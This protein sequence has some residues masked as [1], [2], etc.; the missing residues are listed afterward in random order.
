MS[1]RSREF[2]VPRTGYVVDLRAAD[3]QHPRSGDLRLELTVNRPAEPT[4]EVPTTLVAR[5]KMQPDTPYKTVTILA[6]RPHDPGRD[7][8]I[9]G[10]GVPSRTGS[11]S[12]SK[13][14]SRFPKKA[15]R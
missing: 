12:R 3:Q 11:N 10:I 15:T 1:L 14:P 13:P 5:Y 7:H 8:H 4:I 2:G 9:C 6:R